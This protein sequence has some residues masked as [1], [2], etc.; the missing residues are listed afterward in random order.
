[1]KAKTKLKLKNKSKRKSHWFN[2][3][4]CIAANVYAQSIKHNDKYQSVSTLIT[5][6][7]SFRQAKDY[8]SF[9]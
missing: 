1:M 5:V 7:K 3:D 4:A 6:C 8:P 9:L 2:T